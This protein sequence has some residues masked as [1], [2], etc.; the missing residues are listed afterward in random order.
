[1]VYSLH[2][3]VL[4]TLQ[5]IVWHGTRECNICWHI[6]LNLGQCQKKFSDRYIPKYASIILIDSSLHWNCVKDMNVDVN[7]FLLLVLYTVVIHAHTT[8]FIKIL[9]KAFPDKWSILP[10][11]YLPIQNKTPGAK[12]STLWNV[13]W[14]EQLI[15]PDICIYSALITH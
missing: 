1:M 7:I 9:L 11:K 13:I 6:T 10:T 15:L 12:P 4:P 3:N 14:I 5:S 8:M 2:H